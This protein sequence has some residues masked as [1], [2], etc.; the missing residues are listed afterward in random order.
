MVKP[1][2]PR[3]STNRKTPKAERPA[4]PA[5][6]NVHPGGKDARAGANKALGNPGALVN[7]RAAD[8]LRSGHLWVYASDIEAISLPESAMDVPPALL[9]VADHRG[10]LLG[11]TAPPHRSPCGLSPARRSTRQSGFNCWQ[12]GCGNPL[13][14]ASRCSTTRMTPAGSASAKLTSFPA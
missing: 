8:R 11:S 12:Q 13:L 4:A 14:G 9:P 7:R 1:Q 10:L 3:P 6:Q 5:R 2:K